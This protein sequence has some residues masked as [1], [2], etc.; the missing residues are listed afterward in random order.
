MVKNSEETTDIQIQPEKAKAPAA[1][2]VKFLLFAITLAALAAGGWYLYQNPDLIKKEETKTP[3]DPYVISLENKI[4]DLQQKLS[5]LEA[6]NAG[7]ISGRELTALHERIDTHAR[8]NREIL[9]SK[10]GNNTV[11]GLI[12]RIDTLEMRVNNLGKVSSGSALVLTAAMLV[13]DAAK[14]NQSFEYEAAVLS[15]LTEGTNMQKD[16]EIISQYAAEGLP[17]KSVLISQFNRLFHAMA[18]NN[19]DTLAIQ[20][21]DE[22]AAQEKDWKEKINAQLSRFI[23]VKYNNENGEVIETKIPEDEIYTLVNAGKFDQAVLKM[24]NDPKYQ[25]SAYK[26]W[27]KKVSARDNFNRAIRHIKALTLAAMKIENLTQKQQ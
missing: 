26:E 27:Q 11:L 18:E 3:K 20:T 22:K 19:K 10:A 9:D 12:N 23:T 25:D 7:K 2:I 15:Q 5:L 24:D 16:A 8:L 13:D 6:D 17:E 1:G 14:N 21:T 4:N